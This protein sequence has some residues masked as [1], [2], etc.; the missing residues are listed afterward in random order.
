[1]AGHRMK[2]FKPGDTHALEAVIGMRTIRT[3][4]YPALRS[5][6]SRRF[7]GVTWSAENTRTGDV[8]GH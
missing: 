4:R 8:V 6:P 5:A 2:T 1:M 7:A 3:K